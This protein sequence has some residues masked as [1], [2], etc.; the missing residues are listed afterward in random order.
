MTQRHTPESSLPGRQ[1]DAGDLRLSVASARG[2][3][4]LLWHDDRW[5]MPE[6]HTPTTDIFKLPLGLIGNMG[7]DMRSSG[8]PEGIP[9]R[10]VF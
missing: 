4:D 10:T 8:P 5:C 1:D 2:K 3:T 7:A 6:S 9:I